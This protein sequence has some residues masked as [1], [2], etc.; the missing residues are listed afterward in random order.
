MLTRAEGELRNSKW[1]PASRFVVCRC[2]RID[3]AAHLAYMI[4][5]SSVFR[6]KEFPPRSVITCEYLNKC[7][8]HMRVFSDLTVTV[9][10]RGSGWFG[11]VQLRICTYGWR[12]SRCLCL[13]A[14]TDDLGVY[15]IGMWGVGGVD[16]GDHMSF[17]DETG[18]VQLRA[19]A[20]DSD[21]ADVLPVNAGRRVNVQCRQ[22]SILH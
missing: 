1:I 18:T 13:V 6:Y 5:S 2:K 10:H 22:V 14:D 12:L 4:S 21:L 3:S 7:R 15:L 19:E 8:R 17:V 9:R 11:F 20:P 16:D